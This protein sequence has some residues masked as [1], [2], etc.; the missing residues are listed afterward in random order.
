MII[1]L[2]DGLNAYVMHIKKFIRTV[3]LI[4]IFI[5]HYSN[6]HN[7]NYIDNIAY[8]QSVCDSKQNSHSGNQHTQ[9]QAGL[10]LSLDANT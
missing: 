5:Q 2:T 9:Y 6:R 4:V 7:Q 8:V 1:I 10:T 3:I